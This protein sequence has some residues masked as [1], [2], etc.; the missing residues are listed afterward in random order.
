MHNKNRKILTVMRDD[1][2]GFLWSNYFFDDGKTWNIKGEIILCS[3]GAHGDI[4]YPGSIEV[5]DGCIMTAFYTHTGAPSDRN[6][7][8][9]FTHI[10]GTK[11]YF[12]V[13][14]KV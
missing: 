10:S 13:K 12:F 5:E 9:I 1:K 8:D 2:S 3:D 11:V 14:Y 4:G 7:R 6:N